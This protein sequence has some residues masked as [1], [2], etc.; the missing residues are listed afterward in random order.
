MCFWFVT[1]ATPAKIYFVIFLGF[2]R[3]KQ[4]LEVRPPMGYINTTI[5]GDCV[6]Q[7]GRK[8]IWDIYENFTKFQLWNQENI[9]VDFH[10]K[11][12]N[13]SADQQQTLIVKV[14]NKYTQITLRLLF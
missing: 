5:D 11:T 14:N 7:C 12:F 13:G 4:D 8:A 1:G 10:L 3:E 2:W 6:V 9:L